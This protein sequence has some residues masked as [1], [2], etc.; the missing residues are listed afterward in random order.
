VLL[1]WFA[2]HQDL[3]RSFLKA[4]S[5]LEEAELFGK[6]YEWC[7]I[8]KEMTQVNEELEK[9][10]DYTELYNLSKDLVHRPSKYPDIVRIMRERSELHPTL[11]N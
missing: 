4:A 5:H 11:A 9:P 8:E 10:I 3:V 1:F 6:N 2:Y 7:V